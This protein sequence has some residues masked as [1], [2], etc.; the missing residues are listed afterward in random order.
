ME[1]E[2]NKNLKAKTTVFQ[3]VPLG[4]AQN[5]KNTMWLVFENKLKV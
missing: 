4:L 1:K 5:P 3:F 2:K